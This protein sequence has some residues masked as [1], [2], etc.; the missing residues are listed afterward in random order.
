MPRKALGDR[1][2]TAAERQARQR[3]RNATNVAE[4]RV[5]LQR[6]TGART[7]YEARRI[8]TNALDLDGCVGNRRKR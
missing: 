3:E 4:M 5:A 1:P 6:I 8:A 2:L 7:V